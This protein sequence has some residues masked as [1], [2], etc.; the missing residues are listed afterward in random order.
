M[1]FDFIAR[2][3]VKTVPVEA[4]RPE[5]S[6]PHPVSRWGALLAASLLRLPGDDFKIHEEQL[7]P[8]KPD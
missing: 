1:D 4:G 5:Q 6:T 3:S 7:L 2:Q 8:K